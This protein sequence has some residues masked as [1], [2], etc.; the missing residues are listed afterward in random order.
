M[1]ATIL[2]LFFSCVLITCFGDYFCSCGEFV[3]EIPDSQATYA[4][5]SD[6]LSSKFSNECENGTMDLSFDHVK[7]STGPWPSL[8]VLSYNDKVT[9]SFNM[10]TQCLLMPSVN[11]NVKI[12][13]DASSVTASLTFSSL[14]DVKSGASFVPP[15]VTTKSVRFGG[16]FLASLLLPKSIEGP[17]YATF[18]MAVGEKY[19]CVMQ[20]FQ[21]ITDD[22]YSCA[23]FWSIH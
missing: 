14:I 6:Y 18:E 21:N 16:G 22:T 13:W 11:S 1:K 15:V 2:L 5:C 17:S 8:L 3:V 12:T 9:T 10:T 7:A 20:A 23:I 19:D 4:G